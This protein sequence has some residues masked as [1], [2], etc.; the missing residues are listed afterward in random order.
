MHGNDKTPA[1]R[2]NHGKRPTKET[3]RRLSTNFVF[4]IVLS[5][6]G[7]VSFVGGASYI[8]MYFLYVSVV[9]LT[10]LPNYTAVVNT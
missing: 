6:G 8:Y 4:C 1:K 9:S 10:S 5:V 7:K 3:S 2:K